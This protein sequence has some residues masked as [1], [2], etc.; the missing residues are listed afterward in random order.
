MDWLPSVSAE[1]RVRP[2]VVSACPALEPTRDRLVRLLSPRLPGTAAV[3]LSELAGAGGRYSSL[4]VLRS[5]PGPAERPLPRPPPPGYLVE[6]RIATG[7]ALGR[8]AETEQLPAAA[9]RWLCQV[10]C[11]PLADGGRKLAA[12]LTAVLLSEEGAFHGQT[13]RL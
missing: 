7:A 9:G 8:P 4:V 1:Y 6:V 10:D 13:L 2:A 12:L 11:A 3:P 5:G